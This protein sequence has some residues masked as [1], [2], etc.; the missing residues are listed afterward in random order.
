MTRDFNRVRIVAVDIEAWLRGHRSGGCTLI[1]NVKKNMKDLLASAAE[2]G[3]HVIVVGH[4]PLASHGTHGGFYD[5]QDYLF[6]LTRIASILWLQL[7]VIG[8]VYPLVRTILPATQDLHSPDYRTVRKALEEALSDNPPLLYAAG[9]DHSLQVLDGGPLGCYAVSG[10]GSGR[11]QTPVTDGPDTMFA[12][13][14]KAGFMVV[15]FWRAGK[16]LLRVIDVSNGT[17]PIFFTW[18]T[19]PGIPSIRVHRS[20]PH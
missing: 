20:E 3:L 18:L 5:W 9:H 8:S 15:D 14:G 6:P 13:A 12:R 1:D 11:K 19:G 4:H 2:I 7:P 10:L 17:S 16:L